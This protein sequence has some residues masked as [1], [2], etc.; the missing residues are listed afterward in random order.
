MALTS[1]S[2]T[3][4]TSETTVFTCPATLEGAAHTIYALNKTG[5]A[6]A[7]TLRFYDQSEGLLSDFAEVS[8]AANGEYF[9]PKTIDLNAGDEIR[10]ISDTVDSVNLLFSVY[11]DAATPSETGF[12]PRGAWTNAASYVVNDLVE[13]A[14]TSYIAVSDNAND[15]PPSSNWMVSASKGAQGEDGLDGAGSGDMQ[16]TTYDPASKAEQVLTVGDFIDEDDFASND[17]EKIPSQ[18]S[19]KAYVD[20]GLGSKV[21]LDNPYPAFDAQIFSSY[22]DSD[23]GEWEE[24]AVI[25]SAAAS[26]FRFDYVDFFIGRRESSLSNYLRLYVRRNGSSFDSSGIAIFGDA[27]VD[28]ETY[29]LV[30][31]NTAGTIT[32][33]HSRTSGASY[34]QRFISAVFTSLAAGDTLSVSTNPTRLASKPTGDYTAEVDA[35]TEPKLVIGTNVQEYDADTAK[36]DVADQV[37]TG[38]AGVTPLDLGTVTTGTLTPDPGDRPLQ[39]YIANGAHTLAPHGSVKGTMILEITMGASAGSIT[40]S[41]FDNVTGDSFDTTASKKY[42]CTIILGQLGSRLHVQEIA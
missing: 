14:G 15:Q 1:V 6:V 24:I 40:T 36:L 26:G 38:G 42:E 23:N 21:D 28:G 29:L 9:F 41:G 5:N 4:G 7:L 20:D 32:L 2:K 35:L 25:T 19:V 12:T 18:Q 22:V 10:A 3:I 30:A 11:T 37:I 16:E 33:Y 13:D 27:V 39:Y 31:D 17:N 8:I 34:D